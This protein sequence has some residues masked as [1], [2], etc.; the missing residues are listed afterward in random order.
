M[1]VI[2]PLVK[3]V[4]VGCPVPQAFAEFTVI[5]AGPALDTLG[6][7]YL[8]SRGLGADAD[9]LRFSRFAPW[10][11]DSDRSGSALVA[12]WYCVATS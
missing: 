8:A 9:D 6:S 11:Y 5:S 3:E 7:D 4:V 1:T 2:P 10:G 12:S